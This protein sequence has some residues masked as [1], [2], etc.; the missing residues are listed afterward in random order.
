[1]AKTVNPDKG[2]DV[3]WYRDEKLASEWQKQAFDQIQGVILDT[4]PN[5]K[6]GIKW[7]QPVWETQEGPMAFF[8]GS[9]KHVTLGFWRGAEMQDTRGLLEGEGDRMKH[10]KFKRLEDVDVALISDYVQQAVRLNAEKGNPTK[11]N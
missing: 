10:L 3:L 9:A 4:Y 6:S 2:K 8:R 5:A 1:M 7:A 11:G